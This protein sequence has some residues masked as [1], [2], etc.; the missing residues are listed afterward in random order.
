MNLTSQP[1]FHSNIPKWVEQWAKLNC[2][3]IY[4]A[5][6]W[7]CQH[8]YRIHI[9]RK[10]EPGL[11]S[12]Y[13][14]VILQSRWHCICSSSG[15]IWIGDF[16][17]NN[18]QVINT[19][20]KAVTILLNEAYT[21]LLSKQFSHIC[22]PTSSKQLLPSILYKHLP[23]SFIQTLAN[24][25]LPNTCLSTSS[26]HLPTNFFQNTCLPTSPKR[27]PT[28]WQLLNRTTD[29]PDLPSHEVLLRQV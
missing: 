1:S 25:L 29:L 23:I 19:K 14:G 8:S 20:Q 9:R 22:L 10:Y 11:S 21:Y 26:K 27:L 4:I 15:K 2:C 7:F 13:C 3:Y 12:Q 16:S 18:W 5:I 24:Q 17:D 6:L 28:N